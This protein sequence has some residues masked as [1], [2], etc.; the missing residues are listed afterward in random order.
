M[1]NLNVVD[2]LRHCNDKNCVV[3]SSIPTNVPRDDF[4]VHELR[5]REPIFNDIL[6]SDDD[7]RDV[8]AADVDSSFFYDN[9]VDC[10]FFIIVFLNN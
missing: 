5:S 2:V 9:D 1:F 4:H 3:S 6:S 7:T 10:N 8:N